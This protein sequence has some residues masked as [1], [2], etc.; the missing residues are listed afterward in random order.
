M[1]LFA[2]TLITSSFALGQAFAGYP[3]KNLHCKEVNSGGDYGHEATFNK[4]MSKA[5]ISEQTF[6]GPRSLAELACQ[7]NPTPPGGTGDARY[8]MATC[9]EPE[10]RD[11][12]YSFRVEAGENGMQPITGKLYSITIV[13]E[14]LVA[15][16]S[17]RFLN[18]N[19]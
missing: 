1:K 6:A 3:P 7:K 15:N 19:E 18:S 2:L 16:M 4:D 14:K 13:G 11:A 10:L 9:S 5:Y 12:G 17:C 8:I